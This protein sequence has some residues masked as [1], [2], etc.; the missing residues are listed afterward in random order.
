MHLMTTTGFACVLGLLGLSACDEADD[1]A[2]LP[3]PAAQA[4][5]LRE[6]RQAAETGLRQTLN[7]AIELSDLRG[8]QQPT[9]ESFALCG[10]VSLVSSGRTAPFIVVANR[11]ADGTLAVE[12]HVATDPVSATRVYVESHARCVARPSSGERRAAPPRLPMVP[13]N[14]PTLSPAAPPEVLRMEAQ[15]QAAEQAAL[16]SATLRQPGNMRAHPHGGGEVLRVVPRGV[17]LQVFAQAPGGWLQ[18]GAENPEGWVH[19]SMLTRG[20]RLP[21]PAPVTTAGR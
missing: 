11:Q 15:Q 13:A 18:L 21:P 8:F 12:Q 1:S 14:L 20:A 7:A 4:E 16:G 6:A 17:T 2:S 9:P 3:R 19:S 5:L 10:Q